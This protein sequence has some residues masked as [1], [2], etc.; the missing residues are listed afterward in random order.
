MTAT[1]AT[2]S[3]TIAGD[4]VTWN[5]GTLNAGDTGERQRM[6]TVDDLG[7]ADPLVRLT[8]AVVASTTTSARASEVTTVGTSGLGLAIVAMPDPVGRNAVLTYQ[9]TVTNTGP[10]DAADVEIRMQI[11]TGVAACQSVSDGGAT[12]SGCLL[13]RDVLWSLGA[14]AKGA[15]RTVT[16][17]FV[18]TSVVPNGTI[19]HGTARSQDAGG[20]AARADT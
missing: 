18:T 8:R 5:I 19:I 14:L 7:A 1:G 17:A 11:P 13:G 20:D 6:V 12:V 2:G 16:A 4:T 10:A 15:N 9:L 3:G